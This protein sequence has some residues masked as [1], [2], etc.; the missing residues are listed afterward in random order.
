[1]TPSRKFAN[2]PFAAKQDSAE[3]KENLRGCPDAAFSKVPTIYSW[4]ANVLFPRSIGLQV[5]A[6]SLL[7]SMSDS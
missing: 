1:V 7:T 6:A 4:N 3:P 2:A 5:R